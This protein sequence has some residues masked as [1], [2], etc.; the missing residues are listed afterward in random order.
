LFF[1]LFSQTNQK[2][3]PNNRH[4]TRRGQG[5]GRSGSSKTELVVSAHG[6]I[7]HPRERLI[8]A[9]QRGGG[10]IMCELTAKGLIANCDGAWRQATY[11]ERS[12]TLR[13]R[14]CRPD[15]GKPGISKWTVMG[16]CANLGASSSPPAA[17]ASIPALLALGCRQWGM[18]GRGAYRRSREVRR[19]PGAGTPCRPGSWGYANRWRPSLART[20][21]GHE[22]EEKEE[23]E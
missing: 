23:R 15:T 4:S 6:H 19:A 21:I 11:P 14:T 5:C 16:G 7:A 1:P 17:G 9:F 10:S 22:K 12:K 2:R 13:Y 8:S 18:E 20:A 3:K